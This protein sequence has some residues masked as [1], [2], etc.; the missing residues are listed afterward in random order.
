MFQKEKI[1]ISLEEEYTNINYTLRASTTLSCFWCNRLRK[2]TAIV[3][4]E[5]WFFCTLTPA[6]RPIHEGDEKWISVNV[7]ADMIIPK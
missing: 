6:E 1:L 7:T 2:A 4:N 5:V 3:D